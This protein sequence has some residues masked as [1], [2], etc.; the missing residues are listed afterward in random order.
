MFERRSDAALVDT[1]RRVTAAG[2]RAPADA[3]KYAA[4]AEL[5][6]R[7]NTGEHARGRATT[8]DAA[9]AEVAAAL[10]I[11]HGRACGEI[12]LAVVLRDRLPKVAALFLSGQLNGRRVWLI[13]NR[14]YLVTDPTALTE[15]DAA[16]AERITTWG[17]LSEYKLTQ[18][19][20]VWVD[21]IDPGALRRTRNSARTR[22]FTVADADATGT[23]A[24]YGRLFATDAALLDQRLAAMARMVCEDDP[25]TPAQRR[26]DA[27]GALAAQAPTRCP[28]RARTPTAPPHVDDGRASSVVVHVIAEQ[29]TTEA[30]PDPQTATATDLIRDEAGAEAR[31]ATQGRP[32]PGRW[33]RA[34]PAAGRPHRRAALSSD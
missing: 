25:R 9:A 10:N 17:P 1:H 24:V 13:A 12:D 2:Q 31:G 15:L 3:R 29:A 23:A 6:R 19:I 27:R 7:R 4:I 28:A 26:A 14:T 22:D 34:R 21:Q 33:T 16:I 18:A 20:D 32:D 11:G 30:Q 5:E 8:V